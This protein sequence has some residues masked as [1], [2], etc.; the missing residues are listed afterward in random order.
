MRLIG[1]ALAALLALNGCV[2]V[3][4]LK[5][6]A[7]TS[8]PAPLL[9]EGR[10]SVSF[11]QAGS[12][13]REQ[14]AFEWKISQ[15]PADMPPPAYAGKQFFSTAG[16]DAVDP[17]ASLPVKVSA[18]TLNAAGAMQLN[19][20][21]PLG[22]AL[23]VLAFDPE[24]PLNER[25]SLNTPQQRYV[26]PDLDRLMSQTL[27]WRLPL[28]DLLAWL[29]KTAP[30]QTSQDW[31]INVSSRHDSGYPKLILA[32]NDAMVINVRLVLDDR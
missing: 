19:L 31:Q 7:S 27:G 15:T 8:A 24:A 13:Q 22:G 29:G 18:P 30:K 1:I 10:F 14:G 4:E 6:S 11:Q 21:N 26:A 17:N 3:P 12:A 9:I 2:S 16:K 20:L 25:A 5:S 23:A 28:V 32:K